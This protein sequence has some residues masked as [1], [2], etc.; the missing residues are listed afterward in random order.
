[1]QVVVK[2]LS[3]ELA[4]DFLHFFDDVAFVDNKDWADCYCLFYHFGKNDEEWYK[5]TGEEN[6]RSAARAI[7]ESRMKGYLAFVDDQPVGWCNANDKAA[8]ARIT[9]DEDMWDGTEEKIASIV[10]FIVAPDYRR[11]GI[12]SQLLDAVCDDYSRRGYKYV[13][14]YPRKGELTS[15]QHYHGPLPM[16]VRKGFAT[17]KT[18][19]HYDI[20]RK[21]L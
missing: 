5:R 15:A 11:R 3:P 7:Q 1:M 16:Y 19:E 18:L 9:S 8:F 10:C 2:P 6:R 21:K 20:I 17:Y 12:A 14:A 13:E 4:G